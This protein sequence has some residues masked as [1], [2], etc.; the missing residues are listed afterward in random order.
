[1]KKQETKSPIVDK[2]LRHPAQSLDEKLD[3]LINDKALGY[4]LVTGIFIALALSSWLVYFL[5]TLPNPFLLTLV[6]VG[7]T[8]WSI[9]KVLQIKKEV[10]NYK[11]GRDGEREVG[12]NLELLRENGLKVYHDIVGKD[13][14]IDHV[15]VGE[16]GI[17][18]I[19]TKTYSKPLEGQCEIIFNGETLSKNGTLE[20]DKPIRQVR[21]NA[22]WLKDY[23]KSSTGKEFEVK[24]IIVFPGWFTKSTIRKNDLFVLNPKGLDKFFTNSKVILALEDIALITN[25]IEIY[26]RNNI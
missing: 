10:K 25:R 11:Q 1:M 26:V 16:Q 5:N 23:L 2:S 19:E 8:A 4:F 14:N 18:V 7:V 17:F 20:N 3:E 21:A 6:A 15:L 24:S 9:Y 13:F 22:Q 12:M